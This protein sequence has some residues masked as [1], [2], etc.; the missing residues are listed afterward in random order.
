MKVEKMTNEDWQK[1]QRQVKSK[2]SEI[3]MNKHYCHCFDCGNSH[4][5]NSH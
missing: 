5:K 2:K 1:L 3:R 4:R